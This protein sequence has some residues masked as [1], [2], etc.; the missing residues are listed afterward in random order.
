M[1]KTIIL[2]IIFLGLGLLIGEILYKNGQENLVST[3]SE[4]KNYYFLQ[5]GVYNSKE[6]MEENT[7]DLDKKVVDNTDDKYYV[8]LGITRNEENAEK[9]KKIYEEEGYQ[10]YTKEMKFSNEE[11]YNNVTQFDL[12]IE[13]T[14]KK[15]EVLAVEEVVLANYEEIIKNK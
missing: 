10:I 4:G 9:I 8:Y 11:F 5:E 14:D 3:F 12:L 6:V 13:N 7:K 1:K 2:G 15:E